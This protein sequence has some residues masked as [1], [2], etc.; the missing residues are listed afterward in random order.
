[1]GKQPRQYINF[2]NI[3]ELGHFDELHLQLI[4]QFMC[5]CSINHLKIIKPFL[6]SWVTRCVLVML[7]NFSILLGKLEQLRKN[8]RSIL[9]SLSALDLLAK[10]CR[11]P[12]VQPA[13]FAPISSS[14]SAS[15][16]TT[17]LGLI[18]VR[19]NLIKLLKV[20]GCLQVYLLCSNLHFSKHC[21]R[22]SHASHVLPSIS[23]RVLCSE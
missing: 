5:V 1:M 10:D 12:F 9:D 19:E 21:R 13:N 4:R 15:S 16:T 7:S 17:N 18:F 3:I 22:Q 6:E 23:Y 11:T 8:W 20:E 14:R 2:R